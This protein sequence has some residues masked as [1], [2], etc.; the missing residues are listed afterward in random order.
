MADVRRVF[1]NPSVRT[2]LLADN[3]VFRGA[4]ERE[5]LAAEAGPDEPASGYVENDPVTTTPGVP[6]SDAIELLDARAEP[7]L[8]VL[9]DQG[10][11]LLGLLSFNRSSSGFCVK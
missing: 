1:D 2:V 9:D 10:A 11:T 8:I 6:I 7:R 4:I 5:L 3:G